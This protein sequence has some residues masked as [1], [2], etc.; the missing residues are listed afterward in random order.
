[1]IMQRDPNDTRNEDRKVKRHVFANVHIDNN[2][3]NLK[4]SRLFVCEVRCLNY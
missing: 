1:M 2:Y 4:G 3:D